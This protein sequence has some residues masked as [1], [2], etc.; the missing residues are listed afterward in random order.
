MDNKLDVI[1]LNKLLEDTNNEYKVLFL[2]K[3][4]E[5]NTLNADIVLVQ[6]LRSI[7]AINFEDFLI[8]L[9]MALKNKAN[10]NIYI[11]LPNK[12]EIHVIGFIYLLFFE[13]RINFL[14]LDEL[15][16][17]LVTAGAKL[18]FPI[19]KV[20]NNN[21]PLDNRQVVNVNSWIITNFGNINQGAN[22]ILIKRKINIILDKSTL[23]INGDINE[24][25][26]IR[27]HSNDLITT[28]KNNKS[29]ETL[30][31]ITLINA[32]KY[33]N[34]D[35]FARV[36][37]TGI[38]PS[39]FMMTSLLNLIIRWNNREIAKNVLENMLLYAVQNG[40]YIDLEQAKLLGFLD[41]NFTIKLNNAYTV[42][43]WKKHCNI[44]MPVIKIDAHKD[45][46]CEFVEEKRDL[47]VKDCIE[48]DH[49][50]INRVNIKIEST[51][52]SKTPL[53]IKQILFYLGIDYTI[54]RK[55]YCNIFTTLEQ[56]NHNKLYEANLY[57]QKMASSI[58][59]GY[60]YEFIG[61]RIPMLFCRNTKEII[62]ESREN[63]YTPMVTDAKHVKCSSY[64]YDYSTLVHY[65]NAKEIWCFLY[66]DFDILLLNKIN[67][68][69]KEPLS[70]EFLKHIKDKK[71]EY[72]LL[73][74][75]KSQTVHDTLMLLTEN[76]KYNDVETNYYINNM[77]ILLANNGIRFELLETK[78]NL[79]NIFKDRLSSSGIYLDVA[80]L[81]NKM[82]INL[83]AYYI[84]IHNTPREVSE[85]I[86]ILQFYIR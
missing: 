43:I 47:V 42:P 84:G 52:Y 57:K 56:S 81:T 1:D 61:P 13:Q 77:I 44:L 18:D 62:L 85:I 51:D 25:Y 11:F 8:I 82:V 64:E 10:P 54:N 83:L 14:Q 65:R 69:E 29:P 26:I 36:I 74:L 38:T 32:V 19:Y 86:N 53:K 46:L 33:L 28:I 66:E 40:A 68:Y 80:V 9:G 58:L 23:E 78:N 63:N 27:N 70:E 3:N 16:A 71:A 55:I 15:F 39:Y 4:L 59:Y 7:N 12:G 60:I 50:N 49:I 73:K 5:Y 76:D 2:A 22:N 41:S 45:I 21:F 35:I 48:I 79:F 6:T 67:P 34:Y 75:N 20:A 31:N 24:E 17:L 72:D 30:D 37:N